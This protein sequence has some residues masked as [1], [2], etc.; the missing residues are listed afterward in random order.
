MNNPNQESSYKES[1]LQNTHINKDLPHKER[2]S[3]PSNKC[4]L[5]ATIKTSKPSQ[6]KIRIISPSSGTLELWKLSNLTFRESLA[7]TTPILS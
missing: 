2:P 3:P 1:I 4:Q 5:Y 7:G 6:T